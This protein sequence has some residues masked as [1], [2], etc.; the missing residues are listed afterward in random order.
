[1]MPTVSFDGKPL[2]NNIAAMVGIEDEPNT[3]LSGNS[4]DFT[5]QLA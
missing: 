5:I 3:Q 4:H 1:M 2:Q